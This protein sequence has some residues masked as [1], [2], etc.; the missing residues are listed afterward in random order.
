MLKALKFSIFICLL[1]G[2]LYPLAMTGL[3]QLF[4]PFEANGSLIKDAH[5]KVVGSVLLGQMFT[6]PEYFHPRPS[7]NQYDAANSGGSN[8]GATSKKLIER[9]AHNA[10]EYR[11][12]N[13]WPNTI[14]IDAV[15]A[16]GSNL[17]PHISLANALT[18]VS[19]VAAARK[20][21]PE[22]IKDQVLNARENAMSR[23]PY[24]NVLKLNLAL[25][26]LPGTAHEYN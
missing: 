12:T 2:L 25:D 20:M 1:S 16:S 13:Q 23:A 21:S 4:F 3:G 10:V 15:T 24:I 26:R 22:T 18:Q 6:R 14:P 19:R 11:Q 5:G 8:L 17:D 9:I 7:V